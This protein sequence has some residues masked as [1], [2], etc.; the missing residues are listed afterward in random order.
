VRDQPFRASTI[1]RRVSRG[2]RPLCRQHSHRD[3]IHTSR[4]ATGT[5]PEADANNDMG[6][7][8]PSGHRRNDVDLCVNTQ[9][10]A[11]MRA[12]ARPT[13]R[14]G[15]TTFRRSSER[16]ATSQPRQFEATIAARVGDRSSHGSRVEEFR[17]AKLRRGSPDVCPGQGA[18]DDRRL[19]RCSNGF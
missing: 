7:Q 3:G 18:E 14:R 13:P 11:C 6:P 5:Q 8:S 19:L 9:V 4:E 2:T 15:M 1:R 17:T 12:L 10:L 16:H